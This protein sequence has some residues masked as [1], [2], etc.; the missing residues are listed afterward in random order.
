VAR[1]ANATRTA[2]GGGVIRREA[3]ES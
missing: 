1:I 3:I 2:A